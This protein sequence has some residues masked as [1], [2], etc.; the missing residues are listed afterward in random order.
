MKL[1]KLLPIVALAMGLSTAFAVTPKGDAKP[2][3][4]E[5][6]IKSNSKDV[7]L[8]W[9]ETND[10]GNALDDPSGIDES[11]PPS[12]A[13]PCGGSQ[14]QYCARGF[15]EEQTTVDEN[16]MRVPNV[17]ITAGVADKKQP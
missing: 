10:A 17:S 15:T 9:F 3:K 6:T 4:E 8:Y 13:G 1:L 5:S 16:G 11:I 14:S 2:A 7:D 12:S